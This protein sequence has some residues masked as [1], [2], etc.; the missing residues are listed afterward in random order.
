MDEDAG[1]QPDQL[2]EQVCQA[3]LGAIDGSFQDVLHD[4]YGGGVK[5]RLTRGGSTLCQ[6]VLRPQPVGVEDEIEFE[7]KLR[8]GA[9]PGSG[10]GRQGEMDSVPIGV[11]TMKAPPDTGAQDVH[12]VTELFDESDPNEAA[13]AGCLATGVLLVRAPDGQAGQMRIGGITVMRSG[14][15]LA[16]ASAAVRQG[17]RGWLPVQQRGRVNRSSGVGSN[18]FRR[19][20]VAGLRIPVSRHL[21]VRLA[22]KMAELPGIGSALER[23]VV[24]FRAGDAGAT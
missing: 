12:V 11:I 8:E 20:A 5:A 24:G 4:R 18:G 9:V 22:D 1:P 15:A 7:L 17:G 13:D 19:A 14:T 2:S 16:G 21:L 10:E 3:L 6:R 23:V